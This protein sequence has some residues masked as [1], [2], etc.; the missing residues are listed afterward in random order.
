MTTE[1]FDDEK[2]NIFNLLKEM[3][4]NRDVIEKET[5]EQSGSNKWL[6]YRRLQILDA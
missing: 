4:A 5:V 6:E 2:I 1:Q 3:A